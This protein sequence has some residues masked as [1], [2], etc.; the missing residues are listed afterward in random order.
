[1]TMIRIVETFEAGAPVQAWLLSIMPK[2]PGVPKPIATFSE[3]VH[4]IE[5]NDVY[6]QSCL[7]KTGQRA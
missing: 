5:V 1:M 6:V 3:I 7:E 4:L 2:E